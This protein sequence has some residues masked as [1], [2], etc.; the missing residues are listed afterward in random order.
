MKL[1]KYNHPSAMKYDVNKTYELDELKKRI[2]DAYYEEVKKLEKSSK[3]SGVIK[4]YENLIHY[5]VDNE[6]MQ[7]KRKMLDL[8]KRLGRVRES[9]LLEKE[10]EGHPVK[11]V[12]VI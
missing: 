3:F 8:Y 7:I 11:S 12:S 5:V 1:L 2:T 10:L 4:V 9:M 6:R